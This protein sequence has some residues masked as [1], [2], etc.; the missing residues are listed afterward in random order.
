MGQQDTNLPVRTI[1]PNEILR[2]PLISPRE[3][4]E[5]QLLGLSLNGIYKAIAA[6]QIETIHFGRLKKIPTAPLRRLC[7]LD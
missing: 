6:G 1:D 7:G 5:T 3:L 4:F 2:K